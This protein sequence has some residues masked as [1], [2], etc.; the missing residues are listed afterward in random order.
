MQH[1]KLAAGTEVSAA[2][3]RAFSQSRSTR[4]LGSILLANQAISAQDLLKALALQRRENTRLGDI[5]RAHNMVSR[6]ALHRALTEQWNVEQIDLRRSEPSRLLIDSFGVVECLRAG[7][8]PVRR[9]NGEVLIAAHDVS[10]FETSKDALF[11][12]FGPV[13]MVFAPQTEFMAAIERLRH[14][15]LARHAEFRTKLSDSCR[16]IRTGTKRQHCVASVLCTGAL[17]YAF[18]HAMLLAFTCLALVAMTCGL[19]LKILC[20]WA[21]LTQYGQNDTDAIVKSRTPRSRL[22]IV[23]VM[24]PLFRE[25]EIAERLIERLKRQNYPKELLDICLVVEE[26]D[27]MTRAALAAASLPGWMRV[28]AVPQSPLRTKPRALNYALDF[29]QGSIVGVWD[30]EDAPAP[31][32][33]HRV[34]QAFE[35]GGPKTACVQGILDFYNARQNAM[36]RWFAAEYAVWFRIILPGLARLGLVVPL[37]GTT[38]FFQRDILE[39]IGA[40]DAHNVTEDADLGVRLARAGY[41]TRLIQSVTLEEANCRIRPWVHQRSRWLKGYALTWQVH[42]RRPKL[43]YQQL[44]LNAFVG[45]Q[46]LFLGALAQFALAPLLWVFWAPTFGLHVP[47]LAGFSSLFI[48]SLVVL[49]LLSELFSLGLAAAGLVRSG[50]R[51]MVPWVPGMHLYFMLASIAT[52]KALWEVLVRPF[53][54]DKTQ[55]GQSKADTTTPPA[56]AHRP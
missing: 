28:I 22:P 12:C 25:T 56:P 46:V 43:L 44:G 3:Q 50:R 33:I 35:T 23:S 41:K 8:L 52:A 31:D 37:G 19:A 38:V 24:V 55:H 53:Y 11:Q 15:T 51:K 39:N 10:A 30:A 47:W 21:E 54:W 7:I 48:W 5:L 2:T 16:A 40:W 4:L 42:M 9:Q 26:D 49:F 27:T 17:F 36:S 45:F 6:T 20:A 29:C 14:P 1:L 34:V 32:Q 18:P 13:R